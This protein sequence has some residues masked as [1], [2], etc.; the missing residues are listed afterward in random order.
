MTTKLLAVDDSKTMRKVLEIT[1]AGNT[2]DSTIVGSAEEALASLRSNPPQL[3]VVDGHLGNSNG[4]DLCQQIKAA[5]PGVK[6]ILLSSKQRPFDAAKAATVGIDDHF[7]KP[8]DSTKFLDKL[9]QLELSAPAEPA[10]VAQVKAP[11]VVPV[12]AAAVAA[13]PSAPV[14]SASR[15]AAPA[16]IPADQPV[17]ARSV[18]A[19]ASFNK[20]TPQKVVAPSPSPAVVKPVIA[21]PPKAVPAA[22]KPAAVTLSSGSLGGAPSGGASS[23]GAKVGN[24]PSVA[25]PVLNSTSLNSGAVA[26]KSGGAVASAMSEKLSQLGLTSEQVQGVLA[27]SREVV[28]QVVWE[29]V[30]HLA[31]VLIKEEIARLTAE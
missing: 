5:A 3:V 16:L 14:P 24:S 1:F 18:P 12:A 4:Y 21:E 30:P 25:A 13:V 17:I 31:E 6:V 10:P 28:E 9:A 27:L 19:A 23:G 8:F 29:V 2:Y 26:N 11:A 7:D 15:P 20:S 22:S